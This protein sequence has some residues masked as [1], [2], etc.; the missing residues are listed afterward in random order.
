MHRGQWAAH[1]RIAATAAAVLTDTDTFS[2]AARHIALADLNVLLGATSFRIKL[3]ICAM[4]RVDPGMRQALADFYTAAN[5]WWG[6]V[7]E[8]ILGSGGLVLRPD[9]ELHTFTMLMTALEE[10]LAV[11]FLA[12]PESFGHRVE[13]VAEALTVGALALIG[14]AST[15][16]GDSTGLRAFT[17][18]RMSRQKPS[19]PAD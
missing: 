5:A 3:L 1:R 7:Y 2:T 12:H 10:G 9:V 8:Q 15:E 13:E 16:K 19:P 17:D 14:G 18:A 4:R 6:E 11:R